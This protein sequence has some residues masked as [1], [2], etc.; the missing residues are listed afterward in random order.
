MSIKQRV[1]TAHVQRHH[2]KKMFLKI[3]KTI[4][5]MK[6]LQWEKVSAKQ[7]KIIT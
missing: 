7:I 2:K 1:S 3:S 4:L 6:E 5:Q